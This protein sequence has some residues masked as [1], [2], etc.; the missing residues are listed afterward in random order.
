MNHLSTAA[1]KLLPDPAVRV[2][3]PLEISSHDE[4]VSVPGWVVDL[5]TFRTWIRSDEHPRSG[6]FAFLQG[7]LWVDLAMEEL[8]THNLVKTRLT[9]FLGK[10]NEER[11]LGYLFS[12]GALLT[13]PQAGLS[14]EPDLMFCSWETIRTGKA[15]LIPGARHGFTEVEGSPD[16]VVEIVSDSS[17][18]KDREHLPLLYHHAGIPEYWIVD[19][20][21]ETKSEFLI[22]RREDAGYVVQPATGQGPYSPLIG[23]RLRL[24][25]T[26]DPLGNPEFRIAHQG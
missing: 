21:T 9:T 13:H 25:R 11:Y 16:L 15:R 23:A 12:D 26:T 8:L 7:I 5:E 1:G 17:A 24:D 19:V 6:R 2:H 10:L 4:S 20:R 22:H 18:R 14:T 3:L